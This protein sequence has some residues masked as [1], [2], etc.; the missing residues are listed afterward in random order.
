M[1]RGMK[2]IVKDNIHYIK[3]M[4][5]EVPIGLYTYLPSLVEWMHHRPSFCAHVYAQAHVMSYRVWLRLKYSKVENWG[6]T[7]IRVFYEA[8]CRFLGFSCDYGLSIW[9][10]SCIYVP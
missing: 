10:M 1:C 7:G 2:T 3:D 8:L 4:T 5:K 6:S 9:E